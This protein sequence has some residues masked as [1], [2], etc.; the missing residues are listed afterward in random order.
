[1]RCQGT[2]SLILSD[3]KARPIMRIHSIIKYHH[4]L[5]DDSVL[6]IILINRILARYI[7]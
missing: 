1:M 5:K 7:Y 3:R 6:A 4:L 2:L